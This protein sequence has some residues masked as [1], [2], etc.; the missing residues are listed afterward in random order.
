MADVF[1]SALQALVNSYGSLASQTL[2]VG[3]LKCNIGHTEAAAGLAGV[4]K[5]SYLLAS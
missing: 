4:L 2:Y 1:L 3:S 5:V